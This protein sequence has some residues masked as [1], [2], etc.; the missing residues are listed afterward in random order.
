MA[1]R[2]LGRKKNVTGGGSGVHKRGDGLGIGPVGTGG[3]GSGSSPISSGPS[4][5]NMNRGGRK[6]P[7]F[8]LIV[9][10][11]LVLLGGGGGLGSLL[12]GFGGDD[13]SLTSYT[14]SPAQTTTSTSSTGTE[15][16]GLSSILGNFLGGGGGY[17]MESAAT[18]SGNSNTGVLDRSV[19]SSARAKR[20]QIKGNGE[21][22]I[23]IMVY[24]CGTDLESRGA[25]ASK[26]LQ[27][28]LAAN[29]G[30]KINLIIYTGGCKRWQ[31]NVVSSSTNQVYQIKGQQM[32]CLQ[33]D[34]GQSPMVEP[35]T[36]SGFIKWTA[37]N[38]PAN[39]YDLILWDHGGGSTSG[40]GYDEKYA[41]KG[42][43][44]LSGINKALKDGGV[45]FDFVGFDACLMATVETALVVSNYSDYMIASE[46]TEPGIGWYYTDWLKKLS[47]DTSMATIDIG[48]NIVDSFTE[49]CAQNVAGQKT[50]LSLIDLAELSATVPSEL[51]AFSKDTSDLIKNKEYKTVSDARGATR[52]FATSS[53]ID[54]VD[55]VD[56]A[57]R[58]G[59]SEGKALAEALL[60]SVKYNRTSKSM[61]NA[62]GL[63]I[64]FPYK[65]ASK[66]DSMVNTY[67]DIGM[68][69]EYA[70][71]IQNFASL[72]VA[73]QVASGGSQSPM[74]SLF[75]LTGSN[76]GSGSLGSADMISQLLTSFMGSDFSSI[77]GLSSSNTGF[78]G[79][80][81]DIDAASEYIASN[82]FDPSALTWS[83]D[84]YGNSIITLSEDQ[85]SYIKDLELNAFYDDGAGYID[86]GMDN[87][88]EY[89]DNGNLLAPTDKTWLSIESQPVAYYHLDTQWD[90]DS[91][92][93]TGR[94]PCFLNDVRC[95][96]IIAFTSENEDGFIAGARFDYV[97]GETDTIAKNLT[98]LE[99]GDRID[100]IC[101]Y[102]TYN[103]EYKDSYLLGNTL[104]VDKDMKD[105]LIS[106]TFMG[107]GDA[108]MSY[109]FTDIYGQ[110]YW[111]PMLTY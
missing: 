69:E 68:D 58:V 93:I 22:V 40:Y 106:N 52:E 17:S 19:A 30:E 110:K 51:A 12:G 8:F 21:D 31:N 102:Y 36:L 92:I 111:T 74:G 76:S 9:I 45:N 94:V 53:R 25:M 84:E 62:Y 10:I 46:E 39:R 103:K 88:F 54:Q 64:Y 70:K 65:K 108:L 72:E 82:H 71:C 96:L 44:S 90:D 2:P 35:D 107:D 60:G 101:D 86:L 104:V 56:F 42:A 80:A 50:T 100:F 5:G 23:T 4:G 95:D 75:D 81:L 57:N 43:M 18:W 55:L 105:M 32:V 79:K 27:E 33:K 13:S 15:S 98:E 91:Y 11:V 66:V 37:S 20:T 29:I 3:Y 59:T 6:S 34:L 7:L 24:M 109:C 47:S 87:V 26:D 14:P 48:K 67:E 28:M 97:D 49:A 89:D 99:V 83:A 73:G 77:S 61:T 1:N 63:S 78:L 41:S 85:W 16:L 38:F